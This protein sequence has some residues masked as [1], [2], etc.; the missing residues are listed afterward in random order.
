MKDERRLYS[1]MSWIWPIVSPPEDY[2]EECGEHARFLRKHS[3]RP[4]RTLLHLGCGGGHHDFTLK[5]QFD[6]TG[7]DI[8][9][10]MLD[11]ARRLN[12]E[13]EYVEGDMRTVDLRRTFDAVLLLDS[14]YYMKNEADLAAAFRTAHRHLPPGGMFHTVVEGH[15][16][17][18]EQNGTGISRHIRDDLDIVFIENY[19]DPD[20]AD[21]VMELTFLFIIRMGGKLDVVTDSHE[22]GLF[23]LE[24]WKRLIRENGFELIEEELHLTTPP[25]GADFPLLIGRR[26]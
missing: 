10:S 14:V 8:S 1:D 2:V 21:T 6:V 19:Y 4:I 24:T 13:V 20:P 5:E 16:G 23:P 9:P 18:F 7:V 3:S 22:C 26:L 15:A 11:L 12:P 25:E 17:R